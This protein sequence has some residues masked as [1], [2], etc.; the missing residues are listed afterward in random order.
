MAGKLSLSVLLLLVF[1]CPRATNSQSIE[2]A[3]IEREE[4]AVYSAMLSELYPKPGATSMVITNPAGNVKFLD[5]VAEKNIYFA[6]PGAPRV[7]QDTFKDLLQR[8]KS[9][10]WLERRFTVETDY[11]LADFREIK[12]LFNDFA[13]RNDLPKEFKEKYPGAFGF[14]SL[15]RVGF[16]ARMDEAAV[17]VAW[18]CEHS[19][20]GEGEFVLL[21]KQ[22]R[23]WKIVNRAQLYIS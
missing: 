21:S 20:C 10:R 16:N 23:V 18:T 11:A 3:A 1:A 17:F 8:D 7:S 22:S 12:R 2:N 9:N 5:G 14:I 15:S 4:Y 13:I 19:L 6:I